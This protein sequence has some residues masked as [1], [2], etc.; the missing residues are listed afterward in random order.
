MCRSFG[1]VSIDNK[2]TSTTTNNTVTL[3]VTKAMHHT[4]IRGILIQQPDTWYKTENPFKNDDKKV[5]QSWSHQ[6]FIIVL[7]V[8]FFFL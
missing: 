3:K 4:E 2:T 8:S 7:S 6:K 5:M 1:L